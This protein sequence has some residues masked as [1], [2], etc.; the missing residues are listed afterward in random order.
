MSEDVTT[1]LSALPAPAGEVI[2]T[3]SARVAAVAPDLPVR[4]QGAMLVHGPFRYRYATGREG[5]SALVS[6]AVRSGGVSVYVN[7]VRADGTY[8]PAAHA[9]ALGRVKVGKSCITVRKLSELSLPA[10]DD[11]V[12]EAVSLGGAAAVQ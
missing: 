6:F 3:L 4:V 10:F 7:S 2:R 12:R 1:W 9:A 5:D 11:V 8:V